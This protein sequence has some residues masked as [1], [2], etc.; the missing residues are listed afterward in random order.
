VD[1]VVTHRVIAIERASDQQQRFIT[2]GDANPAPDP[3]AVPVLGTA[4]R[5]IA[6][7]R[8]LGYLLAALQTRLG[9]LAMMFGPTLML[10][11]GVLIEIWRG[12]RSRAPGG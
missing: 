9:K 7:V 4:Q 5:R 8:T 1:I 6:H 12:D 11:G 10:A 3:W 2:R